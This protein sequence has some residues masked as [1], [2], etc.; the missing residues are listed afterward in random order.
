MKAKEYYAKY[1]DQLPSPNEKECFHAISDLILELSGEVKTIASQR[2]AKT[3]QATIGIIREINDKYN[4]IVSLFEAK[5][6]ASPIKRDG[7]MSFWKKEMPE[8]KGKVEVHARR[9]TTSTQQEALYSEGFASSHGPRINFTHPDALVTLAM[10][11]MVP[12]RWN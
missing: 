12:G 2:K 7:F 5:D 3:N 8:L 4:A 10:L 6:G 9:L 11:G 1:H